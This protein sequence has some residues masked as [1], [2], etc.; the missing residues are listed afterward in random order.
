MVVR[1]QP[2]I[3]VIIPVKN[4]AR[5]IERC[6]EAVFN[7]S[8]KP[9][10]VLIVD[11]HSTDGTVARAEK[12]PVKVFYQ[13]YGAAGAARQIGLKHAEGEYL[14]FT[15]G[16]CIPGRDWLRRLQAGLNEGIVG[17]G[18][19]TENILPGSGRAP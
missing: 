16:D 8:L 9:H 4:A 14:A 2:K 12:Y 7:Q 11:G 6:L 10:E 17:V 1:R 18:G 3:S 13:D 19:R 15:D 5:T